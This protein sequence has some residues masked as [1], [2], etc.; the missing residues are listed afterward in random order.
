[1]E[2]R[3]PIELRTI[4]VSNPR[5]YC[6]VAQDAVKYTRVIAAWLRDLSKSSP[7]E[8]A[9]ADLAR[10]DCD[11]RENIHTFTGVATP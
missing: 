7:E 3:V 9:R 2:F 4:A 8:P 1:M 5:R 10:V 11:Q 6:G